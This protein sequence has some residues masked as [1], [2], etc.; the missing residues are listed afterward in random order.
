MVAQCPSG[1]FISR[2]FP[3]LGPFSPTFHH[4]SPLLYS[5][6]IF[7]GNS[8][9]RGFS[10]HRLL[11]FHSPF[12]PFAAYS[13]LPPLAGRVGAEFKIKIKIVGFIGCHKAMQ[14]NDGTKWNENEFRWKLMVQN[15]CSLPSA[16]VQKFINSIKILMGHH[17]PSNL[18]PFDKILNFGS[19]FLWTQSISFLILK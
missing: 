10:K 4:P 17:P 6:I 7:H 2:H 16:T 14:K 15:V 8:L 19:K 13:P 18:L 9:L 3:I 1:I 5:S 12:L 11:P